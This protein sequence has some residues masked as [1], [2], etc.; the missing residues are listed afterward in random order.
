MP[1]AIRNTQKENGF[2]RS[3]RS[4]GMTGRGMEEIL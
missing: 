2:P 3:L 1:V 4:L